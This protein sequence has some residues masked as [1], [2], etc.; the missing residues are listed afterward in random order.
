MRI[1]HDRER[2]CRRRDRWKDRRI[3]QVHVTPTAE[4]AESVGGKWSVR[5]FRPM[6]KTRT[7]VIALRRAGKGCQWNYGPEVEP[8]SHFENLCDDL[9]KHRGTGDLGHGSTKYEVGKRS[10]VM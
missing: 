4:P 7:E 3:D 2:K 10:W 6:R 8:R 1:G 5:R 9:T